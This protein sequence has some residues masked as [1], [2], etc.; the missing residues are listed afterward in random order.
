MNAIVIYGSVYG[1]TRATAEA[2]A[3]GLGGAPVLSPDALTTD[4]PRADLIVVGGPTHAHG[5]AT[6]RSRRDAAR[7]AH[8]DTAAA[9]DEWALRDWL[10]QLPRVDAAR[11]AAFD[12]R[13]NKPGWLTGAA[14]HTIAKRLRRHGYTV[15]DT[16][17]FLVTGGEG[18]LADGQ[19]FDGSTAVVLTVWEGLSQVVSRAVAVAASSFDFEQIDAECE[20]WARDRAAEGVGHARAAG[21]QA[22]AHV[23]KRRDTTASAVLEEATAAGADLVVVGSRGFGAVKSILLGS[24][25]RA[26]LQHAKV[27]VL[28]A[29][30]AARCPKRPPADAPFLSAQL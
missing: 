3:E 13:I 18:P 7:A 24:V 20:Q 9:A 11:A 29:P 21:L 6:A 26:V 15:V 23:A 16:S 30:A 2:I 12:T 27:P 17:S 14:S 1:N 8:L 28:V 10:G 22:Q 19:L 25:S 5:M 4:P